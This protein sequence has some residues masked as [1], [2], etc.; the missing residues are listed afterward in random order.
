MATTKKAV[1]VATLQ[2]S[3]QAAP[4]PEKTHRLKGDH[5]QW[6]VEGGSRSFLVQNLNYG[7]L[8]KIVRPD[9]FN[10]E[11]GTGQQRASKQAR[12]NQLRKAYESGEFTPTAWYAS[13]RESH[14]VTRIK[15]KVELDVSAESPLS[16]VDGN[17]RREALEA[18]RSAGGPMQ[19]KVDNLPISCIIY[20][21]PE[22]SRSDFLNL[23]NRAPVD[24]AQMLVMQINDGKVK[25]K[26]RVPLKLALEAAKRLNADASSPFYRQIRFDSLGVAPLKFKSLAASRGG[27]IA[28]S[29][30]GSALITE[31]AGKLPAWFS[32]LVSQAF[33]SIRREAAELL[34]P[35][36]ILCPAP[37][38][39]IGGSTTLLGT[40]NML[41]Y[42]L[43]LLG[44][45]TLTAKD[46]EIFLRALHMTFDGEVVNGEFSSATRRN[47]ITT[48]ARELFGDIL[49]AEDSVVGGHD[50]VPIHLIEL[51]GPQAFSVSTY[52]KPKKVRGGPKQVETAVPDVI[53]TPTLLLEDSDTDP[54]FLDAA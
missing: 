7:L 42:R 26:Q 48:F 12:V 1:A 54:A 18:L 28:T 3:E 44:R 20:L 23:Q 34:A 5:F 33:T 53:S 24:S 8:R 40:M 4:A 47:Y 13:V 31:S 30:Y 22:R 19:R 14:N 10:S 38:G 35:R 11:D 41:A 21:E 2:E 52:T 6:E 45:D 46:E 51:L 32:S 25:E 39:T 15:G 36:A 50:A 27:D 37:E 43:K 16:L 9:Y 17:H 49:E 29:L